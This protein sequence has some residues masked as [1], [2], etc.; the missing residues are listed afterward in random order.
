VPRLLLAAGILS[1]T[2]IAGLLLGDNLKR[3]SLWGGDIYSNVT[4][5]ASKKITEYSNVAI[6]RVSQDTGFNSIE[7]GKV[8]DADD[9]QIKNPLT[10]LA[11]QII[12]DGSGDTQQIDYLAGES[13]VSKKPEQIIATI[14]TI[15]EQI[16]A[17]EG[18]LEINNHSI[19]LVEPARS[20]VA[21]L[22]QEYSA[23]E[24]SMDVASRAVTLWLSR[25]VA[26]ENH[27]KALDYSIA[28]IEQVA[29]YSTVVKDKL[30]KLS[31]LSLRYRSKADEIELYPNNSA[32]RI[33]LEVLQTQIE[34]IRKELNDDVRRAL[35]SI[36]ANAYREYEA[37]KI[38]RD[39]LWL[40]LQNSKMELDVA[41]AL[42]S[43]DYKKRAQLLRRL[44]ERLTLE[45]QRL[46][47]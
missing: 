25:Q 23:L 34:E 36:L 13:E 2:L 5:R 11:R 10:V 44:N 20:E 24:S 21:R 9:D 43:N 45:R 31:T 12:A 16:R 47:R 4:S 41:L 6:S 38:K 39:S 33:D 37:I 19:A 42:S 27:S 46:G 28:E 1:L 26:L 3:L 14:E 22:Q 32:L 40:D 18:G 29:A 17:L 8:V 30:N 7:E 15:S 35:G